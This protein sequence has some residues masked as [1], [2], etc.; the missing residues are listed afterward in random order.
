[1]TR[2]IF[3]GIDGL[4]WEFVNSHLTHLPALNR[5]ATEATVR[6]LDS[7]FPP[8]SIPAWTTIFTG[9]GPAEH[10]VVESID[11]LGSKPAEAV[12]GAAGFLRGRTFW[13]RASEAGR[14]V[15]VVNAFMAYPA[16]PVNGLMVSGPVFVE[17]DDSSVYPEA[18]LD[19]L[20]PLPQL[21]GI[22]DFPT[23]RT[24]TTFIETTLRTTEEQA[25]FGLS[26]LRERQPDLFF[27]NIL[28]ID[29][30]QHFAWRFCDRGDPTYPGANEHSEAV[31]DGYR[32]VDDI[33]ARFV[34]ES[35]DDAVVLVASDHG[36]GR[37]CTRMVF[38][39][40]L[41]RQS[42]IVSTGN[43]RARAQS[44]V[45]EKS[46]RF[47]LGAAARLAVEGPAY[48]VARRIPG[49]KKLKTSS[50]AI[51]GNSP[52]TPS[53]VFGRNAS[54]GVELS[55]TLDTREKA[56][57][58]DQI[59]NVLEELRDE[60]GETVVAWAKKREDVFAGP[61]LGRF[62]DVLFK[63]TNGYGVDFG[64]FGPLFAA[65]PMHRRISGGH[66]DTGIFVAS[67]PPDKLP[68]VPTSIGALY[69][70]ILDLLEVA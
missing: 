44:L 18:A 21:G 37:R 24:M 68:N 49:R 1:V 11:Y 19:Q 34:A 48:A 6:P 17:S 42:G 4:D 69:A 5:L 40:E 52:A 46:K 15:C 13:D 41:L 38:V 12:E 51:S 33:I 57:L 54:G 70:T 16:W 27:L 9:A 30:L 14:T 22:V 10:G 31:L 60:D 50:Y 23:E 56:R 53:R 67:L 3:L 47:L 39:D 65:D 61:L 55:E 28:T 35:G 2:V 32:A 8:D 26:L 63:L 36:H 7:I 43:A 45:L 29:R 25:S 64:I 59:I 62:P 20:G 66:K 58:A